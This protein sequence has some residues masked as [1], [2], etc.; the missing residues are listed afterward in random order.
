MAKVTEAEAARLRRLARGPSAPRRRPAP[1]RGRLPAGGPGDGFAGV[2]FVL[3]LPPRAKQRARTFLDPRRGRHV[4]ATPKATRAFELAVGLAAAAA[5]RGRPATERPV[6]VLIDAVIEGDPADWPTAQDD[7]D[8]DN[9]IKAVWDGI[10]KVVY[11]DD[12]LVVRSREMKRC[13]PSPGIAVLVTP[14]APPPAGPPGAAFG[15]APGP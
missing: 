15:E 12:K 8:L 3:S 5:M 10:R 6:A 11:R 2:S 9:A 7:P 14:A 4:S 1:R 13:G